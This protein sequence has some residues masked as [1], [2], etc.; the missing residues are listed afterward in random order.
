MTFDE[1]QEDS[2]DDDVLMLVTSAV[3][4]NAQIPVV[5]IMAIIQ[6]AEQH[7]WRRSRRQR[8]AHEMATAPRILRNPTLFDECL[9]WEVFI[10]RFGGRAE[11]KIHL[12]MLSDSFTKLLSRH[13]RPSLEV[14]A[15][16]ARKRGGKIHPELCLY[17]CLRFLVGGSYSDIR[18]FTGINNVLLTTSMPV[19]GTPLLAYHFTVAAL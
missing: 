16:M 10:R 12:R 2:D 3:Q 4:C 6:E 13:I 15:E 18:F 8:T 19:V 1:E 7:S 17:A 11:F 14:D 9:K 5:A